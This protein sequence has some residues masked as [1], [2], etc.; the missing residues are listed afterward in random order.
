MSHNTARVSHNTHN[1]GLFLFT[2]Y[3]SGRILEDTSAGED[4][5][6]NLTANFTTNLTANFTTNL[7]MEPSNVISLS[8]TGSALLYFYSDSG[9]VDSGFHLEYW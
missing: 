8:F 4:I 9:V 6:A 5:D 7:I 2:V 3:F 1:T